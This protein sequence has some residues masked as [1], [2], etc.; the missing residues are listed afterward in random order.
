MTFAS[1]FVSVTHAEQTDNH[2]RKAMSID[3]TRVFCLLDRA[4]D[5]KDK[6]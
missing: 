6:A 5:K 2:E 4:W 3:E 1:P